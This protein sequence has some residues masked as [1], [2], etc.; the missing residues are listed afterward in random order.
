MAAV[1]ATAEEKK[2]K[3]S[4]TEL[5]ERHV[6]AIEQVNSLREQL[7]QR[8]RLLL[9]TDVASFAAAQGKKAVS[10][11]QTDLVCCRTLQGHTGKVYSLDW[12]PD[13]NRIVSASQDGRLIVWNALTSQKTHA[14]KLPCAWVM[15]CAFSPSG[16]TVAC[17]GLDSVCS[18]FNLNSTTDR[19]G[20]LPVSKTLSGHK[21]YVSCCQYIPDEDTHLITSSGDQTCILWD[22]TTGLRTSVFG[23]EFQSGHTSDVLS[24]SI[25]KANSK[26][27]VS[28]SC[29]ST[30]RLWDTRVASRAVRTF[31]GHEGDVNTVK[32]FPDGNRFGTGS[33]DGTCR[34][35]DIRTGHQLQVYYEPRGENEVPPVKTIAFSVS[36]RLL[37]AG[38]S[39]GDCYVWDT[40]L[41]EVVLNLGSLQNS[42]G[43]RISCLGLSADGSALC[44][45]SWDTN[46][47]IWAFG[48]H[49]RVI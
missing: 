12:T 3:M 43:G 21:G 24:I 20:N 29:D 22:T 6:A 17:G 30:A 47:K 41:A 38:Y 15:T 39:N 49:R 27:F 34:L 28:G 33:E 2:E 37:F 40:L 19:D 32:F 45:G 23:G 5:K 7:K 26:M 11:G 18:I 25:S 31:Y 13:K 14:I 10:F 4:V 36:G 9:D 16:Q 42:H 1:A 44:T 35:F 8:R 48:G 46:L